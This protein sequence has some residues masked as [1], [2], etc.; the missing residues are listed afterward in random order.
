MNLDSSNNTPP[1]TVTK[2]LKKNKNNELVLMYFG[3]EKVR[4]GN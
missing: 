2:N 1:Q 4:M 3:I